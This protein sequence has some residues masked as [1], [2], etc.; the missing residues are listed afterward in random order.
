MREIKP[1]VLL[2]GLYILL[3]SFHYSR[4]IFTFSTQDVISLRYTCSFFFFFI[5]KPKKSMFTPVGVWWIRLGIAG[6]IQPGQARPVFF[7]LHISRCLFCVMLHFISENVHTVPALPLHLWHGLG[8]PIHYACF[9]IINK[10]H[11][12][13][14]IYLAHNVA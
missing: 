6:Y 8:C 5:K 4:S 7:F 13:F 10:M 14:F 11:V 9:N 12:P 3:L 1:S 2:S